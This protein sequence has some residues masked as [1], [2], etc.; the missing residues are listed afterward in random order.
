MFEF[1]RKRLVA[2]FASDNFFF[3]KQVNLSDASVGYDN[4][5]WRNALYVVLVHLNFATILFIYSPCV[6]DLT[7][8][9]IYKTTEKLLD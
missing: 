2:N 7:C 5:L 8:L 9:G 6:I 4:V 1:L 3:L